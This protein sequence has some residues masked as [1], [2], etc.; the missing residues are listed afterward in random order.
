M[1][2]YGNT[3]EKFMP[4]KSGTCTECNYQTS[5]I[6]AIRC[7]HCE[8]ERRKVSHSRQEYARNWNMFKKYKLKPIEFE[9][10]WVASHGKCGICSMNLKKPTSTRGQSLDVV[11][12]DHDHITGTIRGLLCNGCNK[13][14]GLFRDNVVHLTKAIQWLKRTQK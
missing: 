5:T 4:R 14:L 9:N 2:K 6:K 11:A 1:T 10:L 7:S 8:K 3:T 12:I 13:G